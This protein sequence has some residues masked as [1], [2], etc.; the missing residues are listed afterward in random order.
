[1][2]GKNVR[3]GAELRKRA[4]AVKASKTKKH[5]CPRTGKKMKRISNSIWRSAGG[6]V[7]AGGA[8]APATSSGE[9]FS[10]MV[11][12]YKQKKANKK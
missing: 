1:M 9:V 10:R 4:A 12:E 11:K 2:A 8:Y 7:Y 6:Y 5:I 3:S